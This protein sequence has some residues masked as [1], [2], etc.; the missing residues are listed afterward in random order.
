MYASAGSVFVVIYGERLNLRNYWSGA[1]LSVWQVDTTNGNTL[2]GS[3]KVGGT[4]A[5]ARRRVT[6]PCDEETRQLFSSLT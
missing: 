2:S 3:V 6:A 4:V 1:W 5:S